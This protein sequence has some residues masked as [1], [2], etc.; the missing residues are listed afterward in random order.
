MTESCNE[1]CDF[2]F[3]AKSYAVVLDFLRGELKA[4]TIDTI[5]ITSEEDEDADEEIIYF[6]KDLFEQFG[7]VAL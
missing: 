7:K 1:A 4:F 6:L 5:K 2:P 3:M